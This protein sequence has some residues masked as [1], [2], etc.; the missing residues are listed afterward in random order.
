MRMWVRLEKLRGRKL[1]RAVEFTASLTMRPTDLAG[2]RD[3]PL[4]DAYC[5]GRIP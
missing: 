4:D 1:W 3:G 5:H 2:N